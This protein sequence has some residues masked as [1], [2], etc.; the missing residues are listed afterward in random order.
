MIADVYSFKGQKDYDRVKKEGKLY[1]SENFG[2][3]VLKR[4]DDGYPRFGLIV[5]NKISKLSTQ[6][7]RIK[8]AFRDALRHNL[9]RIQGGYD[10]VFLAKPT[11]ERITAE[12]IMREMDA[13]IR[14]SVFYKKNK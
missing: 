12:N 4:E 5:S 7:N 8:R 6:R 14:D 13:F 9:N 3:S 10:I 11:L 1:Q 2:A